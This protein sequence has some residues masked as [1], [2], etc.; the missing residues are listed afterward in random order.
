MAE[1]I[2]KGLIVLGL[3]P[4]QRRYLIDEVHEMT[5][6][7]T[8]GEL[9]RHALTTYRS[10]VELVGQG[11]SLYAEDERGRKSTILLPD[12]L[13]IARIPIEKKQIG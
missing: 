2:Q 11:N 7:V 5:G 1:T 3:T 6:T 9:M 12:D 4:D 8:N 10:L 13:G